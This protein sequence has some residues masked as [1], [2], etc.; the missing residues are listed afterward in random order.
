M[1]HS[2]LTMSVQNRSLPPLYWNKVFCMDAARPH[3]IHLHQFPIRQAAL[4]V[5]GWSL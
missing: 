5:H 3:Q 4:H 1:E 2:L